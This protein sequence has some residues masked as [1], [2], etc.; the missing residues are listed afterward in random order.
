VI[1]RLGSGQV[2]RLGGEQKRGIGGRSHCPKCGRE[3]AWQDLV[4]VL[5]F[6]WLGGKCRYC[7]EKISW[8]YPIVELA[9]GILFVFLVFNV[10]NFGFETSKFVSDFGFLISDLTHFIYLAFITGCLIVIFVSDLKY[11]IIPDEII[12]AG[13]IGI[14]L[15]RFFAVFDFGF[16]NLFGNWK[17]EIGNLKILGFYVL[18]AIAASLFF[19]VIV[20]VTRG[21]GMGLGD[22]KMAFLMGLILGWPQIIAA[23]L[24]AFIS[25]ALVGLGLILAGRAK[26]KSEIP[27][28]TF[29]AA[30][31]FLVMIFGENILGWLLINLI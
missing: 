29:L 31:T 12:I 15:Y 9:T 25:G 1:L 4:P 10:W 30:S 28:G 2:T 3:L 5:S 13:V 18:S 6:F 16:W 8:Q 20:L 22:V 24:L 7:R 14:F 19:L 23:L 11:F 21:K 27:F 17:L 26:M